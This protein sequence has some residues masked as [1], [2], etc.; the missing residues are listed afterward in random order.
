MAE[1]ISVQVKTKEFNNTWLEEL[2]V[3]WGRLVT[4]F[5]INNPI[6]E[7]SGAKHMEGWSRWDGDWG[8]FM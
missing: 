4:N 5:L 2:M 7:L 3:K 6:N 8:G 1:Q